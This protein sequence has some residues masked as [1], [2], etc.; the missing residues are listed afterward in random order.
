MNEVFHKKNE[1]CSYCGGYFLE[2]KFPKECLICKNISYLNPIPISVTLIPCWQH[3]NAPCQAGILVVKRN[4][5]PKLG[6]WALP[7]GFIELGET[8]QAGAVREVREEV[9][10]SLDSK[11]IELLDLQ[12]SDNGN[13][14]IFNLCKKVVYWDEVEFVP[15]REVSEIK[16]TYGLEDLAFPTHTKAIEKYF[17]SL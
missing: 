11:D 10:L 13:I 6:S 1:H 5:E 14:L 2:G 4:I 7:G 9:G 8:W 17:L 12:N 3:R 16:L 15:N